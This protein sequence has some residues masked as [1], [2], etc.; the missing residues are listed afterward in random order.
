MTQGRGT[1]QRRAQDQRWQSSIV[2]RELVLRAS[3]G[4]SRRV[5]IDNGNSGRCSGDDDPVARSKAA[6]LVG[7]HQGETVLHQIE[8]GFFLVRRGCLPRLRVGILKARSRF[9]RQFDAD[10]RTLSTAARPPIASTAASSIFLARSCDRFTAV[11]SISALSGA[12]KDYRDQH[13]SPALQGCPI[14]RL[15]ISQHLLEFPGGLR[16]RTPSSGSASE[17]RRPTGPLRSGRSRGPRRAPLRSRGSLAALTRKTMLRFH[18]R[19]SRPGGGG[20]RR[21]WDRRPK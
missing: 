3:G 18:G 21:E 4:D 11:S 12:A 7:H 16:P 13:R 20:N 5:S 1:L 17:G 6:A 2:H 10:D 15:F 19:H 8:H 14:G 9:A